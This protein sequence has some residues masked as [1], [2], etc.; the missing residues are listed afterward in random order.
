MNN[1]LADVIRPED[2]V[3]DWE[4]HHDPRSR[5][6]PMRALMGEAIEKQRVL[7]HGGPVLDQS[8]EGACVGFGWTG[9]LLARPRTQVGVSTILANAHAV[10][11]YKAAQKLDEWGGENYSGT[12]VLAGA[13]AVERSG[14]MKGYRWCFG[15]DDVRDTLITNGP[16]VIG[17]N[18][19]ESMYYTDENGFVGV[20]GELVGGHCLLLTGYDPAYPDPE[21][22][23]VTHEMYRWRNSWGKSYGTGGNAWI[24]AADLKRLLS[25]DGEDCVAGERLSVKII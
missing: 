6:F 18:W 16:V 4:S 17:I 13:K 11:T 21:D 9:E 14:M 12:S 15:I 8:R 22:H 23:R 19:Y 24:S 10:R 25:E 3:L 2:R 7:W 5:N 20:A 1:P